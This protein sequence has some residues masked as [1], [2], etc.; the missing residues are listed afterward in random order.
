MGLDSYLYCNSR[1]LT[2]KVIDEAGINPN[3]YDGTPGRSLPNWELHFRQAGEIGYW[4]KTWAIH[5]WFVANVQYGDDDCKTYS[6]EIEH[7]VKLRDTCREVL[8]DPGKAVRLLPE[9]YE[10]SHDIEEFEWYLGQLEYT[11]NI[12][13][14]ILDHLI[15]NEDNLLCSPFIEGE[16]D[17]RIQFYY[18]ASW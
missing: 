14:S 17:W 4:R 8:D 9:P 3:F 18:H 7:L 15:T 5:N 6:V 13:D 12:I 10:F 11:V 2:K 1:T 16:E